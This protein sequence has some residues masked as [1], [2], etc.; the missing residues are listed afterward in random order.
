LISPN[1]GERRA[2][3]EGRLKISIREGYR[4]GYDP[5]RPVMLCCQIDPWCV[6][7][8]ITASR[9][10]LLSEVTEEEYR[11]H[12]FA[13]REDLLAGMRRFYPEMGWDNAVTIVRWDSVQ[14]KLA[15]DWTKLR[16]NSW[17]LQDTPRESSC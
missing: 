3:L 4:E 13:N 11:D 10:C 17:V 9:H 2:I 7:A 8:K 12:G 15:E 5:G 6:M 14:G 16:K 1:Q